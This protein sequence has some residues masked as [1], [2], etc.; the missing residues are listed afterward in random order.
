MNLKFIDDNFVGNKE[1][2][3]IFKAKFCEA[4]RN[5]DFDSKCPEFYGFLR[6]YRKRNLDLVKE[7]KLPWH[8]AIN[9]R[10]RTRNQRIAD[11]CTEFAKKKKISVQF[12]YNGLHCC[13]DKSGEFTEENYDE[14]PFGEPYIGIKIMCDPDNA[15]KFNSVIGKYNNGSVEC[16][17]KYFYYF[18][19]CHG[20][21]KDELSKFS[22]AVKHI[23]KKYIYPNSYDIPQ[24]LKFIQNLWAERCKYTGDIGPRVIGEGMEFIFGGQAYKMPSGSPYKG[25]FS[26][27]NS[28][29]LISK[30]LKL[31]GAED[32]HMDYGRFD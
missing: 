32:I 16:W 15:Y 8:E 7:T 5:G 2:R 10:V 6:R 23:I 25:E 14:V 3:E 31:I 26:W 13:V 11:E 22:D 12:F 9:D 20:A 24:V 1:E 17:N 30:L 28:V 19:E 29:A 4:L 27:T 18:A 21:D